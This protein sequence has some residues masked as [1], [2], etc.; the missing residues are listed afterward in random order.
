MFRRKTMSLQELL[1]GEKKVKSALL[2]TY[3]WPLTI[4]SIEEKL[5][6]IVEHAPLDDN[7]EAVLIPDE[8]ANGRIQLNEKY[9]DDEEFDYLHEVIHYLV[10]VGIGE[11]VQRTYPR[12]RV[13]N[14]NDPHE[15]TI[16]YM[17][18]VALVPGNKLLMRL[19]EY[20]KQWF[21]I[22]EIKFMES[23]QK[24]FKCSASCLR[25]RVR[26]VHRLRRHKLLPLD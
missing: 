12:Q 24:E 14:S 23:L 3:G 22:D 2:D 20:R 8:H 18:A 13:G 7:L 6:L 16:D 21:K 17:A 26:D 19:E 25:K 15:R 9:V 1:D 10:D 11:K 5:S 4:A